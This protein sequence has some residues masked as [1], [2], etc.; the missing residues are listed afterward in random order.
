MMPANANVLTINGGSSSIKFALFGPDQSSARLL[1]GRIEGVGLPRGAFIVKSA[2]PD[3][4]FS[5]P[6]VVPDHAT[7]VKL[8]MDWLAD[9]IAAG[10]L[11]AVAHRIVHGGA[12]YWQPQ[13]ITRQ[14]IE[15][16][17]QLSPFDPEHLPEEIL[18]AEAFHRRFPDLPQVACFDTAFHHDMPRLAQ[19]L[20][21]PRRY[22]A[23]GA[24]RYGFHGL[25]CAYLMQALEEEAGSIAAHGRVIL[26]HLGNGASITAVRA[27]SSM[28]TSMGLTPASGLPMSSRS[29]DLD[30]GL[31][32]YLARTEQMSARQ[33]QHMVNHEAGLAGI[34]ET[35]SDM[36]ELLRRQAEDVRAAEAVALF[37]YQAR[38]WICAL[39]GVLEG[40][41]TLVFAG[42]I[43][44]NAA[45]VR[46]RICS[47]L[48]FI[49]IDVDEASNQAGAALISSAASA[50]SVRVIATDEESMIAQ[51][52]YR[53]LGQHN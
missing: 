35:S 5:R 37:C 49:G 29:G 16:L 44:E 23:K 33:F 43:G 48:G 3:G 51:D 34:S 15:E 27:G 46:S 17:R 52:A 53:V 26:A 25:S 39:A 24:R 47:G 10:S 9:R 11:A 36:R 20:P 4:N 14:M 12:K 13:R 32:W 28:D 2:S 50:V 41:D 1:E 38:K 31:A 45:E 42:G 6:V 40:L 8:L 7:A 21:I 22:Q 19:L 30:P 18:L